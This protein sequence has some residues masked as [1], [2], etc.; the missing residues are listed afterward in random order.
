[1]AF[2]F[3]DSSAVVFEEDGDDEHDDGGGG[4]DSNND[5]DDKSLKSAASTSASPTS[6]FFRT[7]L[8]CIAA[9]P[10]SSSYP[11]RRCLRRTTKRGIRP[12]IVPALAVLAVASSL[13]SLTVSTHVAVA[14]ASALTVAVSA[15]VAVQQRLLAAGGAVQRSKAA[16]QAQRVRTLR[17]ERER[18]CRHILQLDAV[19]ERRRDVRRQLRS[20]LPSAEPSSEDATTTA[21]K[22]GKNATGSSGGVIAPER[23]GLRSSVPTGGATTAMNDIPS[24]MWFAR[25]YKDAVAKLQREAQLEILVRIARAALPPPQRNVGGGSDPRQRPEDFDTFAESLLAQ[26]RRVRGVSFDENLVREYLRVSGEDDPSASGTACLEPPTGV[27]PA[28][29]LSG[30][31]GLLRQAISDGEVFAMAGGGVAA[32]GA[33]GTPSRR[34]RRGWSQQQLHRRKLS[35]VFTFDPEKLLQSGSDEGT[36]TAATAS[37]AHNPDSGTRNGSSGVNN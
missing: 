18:L 31:V 11:P 30:M 27:S 24:A 1:M 22:N 16:R 20:L 23:Y 32:T 29:S 34:K 4:G 8:R 14:L 13:C 15:V 12:V 28:V 25:L 21:T 10:A 2:P 9:A 3:D 5:V 6:R 19:V 7:F 26:L 17:T 36:Q 33:P 37:E 35:T